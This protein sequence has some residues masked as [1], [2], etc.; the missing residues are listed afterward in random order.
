MLI[1]KH[2]LKAHA[3]P[4]FISFFIIIFVFTFQY[5]MKFI[6][7]LVGKGLSYWVIIQLIGLNLAWMVT[8]AGP[9]AVLVA[10]LMAYGSLS[11]DN[12]ITIMQSSG[13][14]RIRLIM[15]VLLASGILCYALVL[16]NNDVL[17]EANHRTKIL[18]ND[19]Q[20]TKPT[21][22][23]EPG[24]FTSDIGGYNMLVNKTYPSSN[25]LEGVLIIDNSTPEAYNVL[26]A[27][28]GE[29]S[30]SKDYSK[31]LMDLYHGEIHHLDKRNPYDDYREVK[32]EKHIVAIEAGGF[33]FTKSD[34]NALSRGDRELSAD[35]MRNI[36]NSIRSQFQQEMDKLH[37]DIISLAIELSKFNYSQIADS[38]KRKQN[39]IYAQVLMN[40]YRNVR[41]KLLNRKDIER[42]NKKQIDTYEVEIDKKYSIPFAC[43]VFVLIGA[44]LGIRIRRGGFGMAAGVSLG[45]FLL[46]WAFLIGGEKLAD[47]EMLSPFLSMWSA[48]ILIGVAGLYL[49]F[50]YLIDFKKIFNI[51]K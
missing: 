13:L 12:E 34:E 19:I 44:P 27:D 11:S 22:V 3:A 47:R 5:I 15:P 17:P 40:K 16:F 4:F 10:T 23:I 37:N 32:F 43:V 21:F 8:L 6:D 42:A 9:M 30:Y 1:Y 20:R 41:S 39:V 14:S 33:G 31:L 38:T 51:K 7:N 26:T 29:I 48:N 28:S 36:V 25:K 46:Y 35:S 2:I 45:F 49:T 18:T 50:G 24:K